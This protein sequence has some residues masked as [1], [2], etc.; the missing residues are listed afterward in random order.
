MTL[1]LR[2]EDGEPSRFTIGTYDFERCAAVMTLTT[3]NGESSGT[4]PARIEQDEA[5][6]G[7]S[8]SVDVPVT[9]FGGSE[10]IYLK[11]AD[12]TDAIVTPEDLYDHGDVLPLGYGEFAIKLTR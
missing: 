5:S 10:K 2:T 7:Y 9:A 12:S 6:D 4:I 3:Q 8:I 11:A 1:Y